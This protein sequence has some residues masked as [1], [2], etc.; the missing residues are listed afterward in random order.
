MTEMHELMC[1]V[2]ADNINA[3]HKEVGKLLL[4]LLC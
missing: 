4:M 3:R 2:C 1:G